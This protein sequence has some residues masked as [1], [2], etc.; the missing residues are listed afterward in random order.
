MAQAYLSSPTFKVD[1]SGCPAETGSDAYVNKILQSSKS[2]IT[3][4]IT[5]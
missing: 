4:D 1:S 2:T 5:A 3:H